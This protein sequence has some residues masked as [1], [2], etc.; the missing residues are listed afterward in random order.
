MISSKKIK[1][2]DCQKLVE[3]VDIDDY[4]CD[5]LEVCRKC[6]YKTLSYIDFFVR[7]G[8]LYPKGYHRTYVDRMTGKGTV[9]FRR[10]HIYE[11]F[12]RDLLLNREVKA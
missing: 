9:T 2:I 10:E 3:A 11:D 12:Y 8:S 6:S 1:C 4:L 7:S 5:L